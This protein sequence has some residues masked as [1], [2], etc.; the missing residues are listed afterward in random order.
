MVWFVYLDNLT[1]KYYVKLVFENN[2]YSLRY[3][4]QVTLLSLYIEKIV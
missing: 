4:Q 1:P 2:S 3:S